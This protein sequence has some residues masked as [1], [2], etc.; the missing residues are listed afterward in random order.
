[1]ANLRNEF[2]RLRAEDPQ[3]HVFMMAV[4]MSEGKIDTLDKLN[5]F[6]YKE[7]SPGGYIND[8]DGGNM[9]GR[10]LWSIWYNNILSVD[11][12]KH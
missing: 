8:K 6:L 7:M 5:Q 11:L 10:S 4:D 12:L 9:F 3:R 2:A 1:M